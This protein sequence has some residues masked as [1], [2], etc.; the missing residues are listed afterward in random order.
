VV[1]LTTSWRLSKCLEYFGAGVAESLSDVKLCLQLR[2]PCCCSTSG[3]AVS[4]T[5]GHSDDVLS[6]VERPVIQFSKPHICTGASRLISATSIVS[7][8]SQS[9]LLHQKSFRL[10]RRLHGLEAP[11]ESDTDL[12]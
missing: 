12:P 9:R 8:L 5:A 7:P 6:T 10:R 4:S 2:L 1:P 11:A 3:I